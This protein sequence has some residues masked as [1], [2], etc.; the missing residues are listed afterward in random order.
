[1]FRLL[2]K[3]G[4]SPEAQRPFVCLNG[5]RWYLAE[6]KKPGLAPPYTCISYAWGSELV[7]NQLDQ[8]EQMSSRTIL[9]AEAA[10]RVGCVDAIWID[11]FCIPFS[12]PDRHS[13]LSQ[14]GSIYGHSADVAVVLGKQCT[15]MLSNAEKHRRVDFS[16]LLEFESD[17]WL[18]RV[19]TYQ[20][21]VN[22]GDIR[23]LSIEG[24]A[25]GV[26]ADELLNH[27]GFAIQ[28][29]KQEKQYDSFAF[30]QEHPRLDAFEDVV[31]DW[32]LGGYLER[33]AY[34]AMCAMVGRA[35]TNPEDY[36]YA[37]SGAVSTSYQ[38]AAQSNLTRPSAAEQFMQLCES[39]NDYSFIFTTTQR[40]RK[41][42]Q[43][44]RPE[45]TGRFAPILPWTTSGS[46]QKGY[47]QGD[48]IVLNDL[49]RVPNGEVDEQAM[50]FIWEWLSCEGDF[51]PTDA[52]HT[53]VLK[54][55]R[56]A[57]FKGC[58]EFLETTAG[59]FFPYESVDWSSE[60]FVVASTSIRMPHSSP[61]LVLLTRNQDVAEYFGVGVFVGAVPQS[62]EPFYIV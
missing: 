12:E 51:S 21:L 8:A 30:K 49:W 7:E 3:P 14:I 13:C 43:R 27:V 58:G 47:V 52:V 40:S 38:P 1:M 59:L 48:G 6:F 15:A 11:A 19:W 24:T 41:A 46:K 55:L 17:D 31:V 57:G 4:P 53:R 32:Q 62:G 34:R 56:Q 18:T 44:W 10:L 23:F 39:N 5:S 45:Q 42:G 29:Y 2:V 54:R 9:A 16:D 20:E 36:F 35:A 61:A 22:G 60:L 37:M 33:S 28:K 26:D 25:N 50:Q